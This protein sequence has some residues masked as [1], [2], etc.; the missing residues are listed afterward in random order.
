[1]FGG[2]PQYSKLVIGEGVESIGESA[3]ENFKNF[4]GDLIIPNSV[5]NCNSV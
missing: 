4:K 3:F 2:N 5:T 1:M